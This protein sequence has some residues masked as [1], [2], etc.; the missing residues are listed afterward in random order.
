MK[1][2][3]LIFSPLWNDDCPDKEVE[4][5]ADTLRLDRSILINA[6]IAYK[7]PYEKWKKLNL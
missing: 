5:R 4:R 3:K 7:Q 2:K 1:K 6:I